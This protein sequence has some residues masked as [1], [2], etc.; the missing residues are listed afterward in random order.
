MSGL[1]EEIQRDAL[2]PNVPVS[3]ILRKVKLAAA[4]LKLT[5]IEDWVEHELNGYGTT[6]LPDYRI[7]YGRPQAFNPYNGWIP[8][9]LDDQEVNDLLSRCDTKQSLSSLEDTISRSKGHVE[10]P[11]PASII[12]SLNRDMRVKFGRMAVHLSISQVQSVVDSVRN[13]ILDWAIGLEKAGISGEGFSFN[14]SE[15]TLAREAA[16]TYNINSIGTFA[17]NM[18]TGNTAGDISVTL[19][20]TSQIL[21]IVRKIRESVPDLERAG[22]D[23]PR[24][25][26]A[27]ESIEGEVTNEKPNTG[28]LK[29]LLS[30]ARE[31]LVGAA[32]NLTAEGAMSLIASAIKL[33][34]S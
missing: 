30:D 19:S 22:A 23:V 15:R 21:E 13:L 4:K 9:I 7:L 29:G 24:L 8:I 32:G 18:G 28:R 26:R 31:A 12:N 33:L 3:T 20:S 14:D 17:G 25:N 2:N 1:V 27:I 6:E 34:G 16:V 11:L 5:K 10:M